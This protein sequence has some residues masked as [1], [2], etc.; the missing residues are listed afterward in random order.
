MIEVTGLDQE[1]NYCF[2]VQAYIPSRTYGKQLGDLS[3]PQCSKDENPSILDGE[4]LY[5]S[6]VL[7]TSC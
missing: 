5:V 6:T 7:T 2:Q 4:L 1:E 3:L